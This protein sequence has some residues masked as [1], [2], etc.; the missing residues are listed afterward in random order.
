MSVLFSALY[1]KC[2]Y[3]LLLYELPI[4]IKAALLVRMVV[5]ATECRATRLDTPPHV[6]EQSPFYPSVVAALVRRG[7]SL[8]YP[9][10]GRGPLGYRSGPLRY[11]LLFLVSK[12]GAR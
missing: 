3:Y 6:W 11:N 7:C 12:P 9:I 4:K 5:G 2:P 1:A 8:V 10:L